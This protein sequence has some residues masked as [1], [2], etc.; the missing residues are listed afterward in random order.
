[1]ELT[2]KL[3]KKPKFILGYLTDMQ[4][5]A[6]V[7]PV[8]SKIERTGN[9]SYL[10]HEKLKLGFIPYSFTYPITIEKKRPDNIVFKAIVMKALGSK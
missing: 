2:F 4:K 7:H 6:F 10:V 9:N 1:M 5:F 8:I 3:T